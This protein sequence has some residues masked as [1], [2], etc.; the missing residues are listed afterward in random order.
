[1][2]INDIWFMTDGIWL[3]NNGRWLM[4]VA[5]TSCA[6]AKKSLEQF[7]RKTPTNQQTNGTDFIG[8]YGPEAGGP[9]TIDG[10]YENFCDRLTDQSV[11]PKNGCFHINK[12]AVRKSKIG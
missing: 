8:P 10:K 2:V 12:I 11:G 9:K 7:P 4:D 6:K 1:M 3:I 5:L